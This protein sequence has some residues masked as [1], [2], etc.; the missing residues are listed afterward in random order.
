MFLGL[1]FVSTPFLHHPFVFLSIHAAGQVILNRSQ[2]ILDLHLPTLLKAL[3]DLLPLNDTNTLFILTIS[4]FVRHENNQSRFNMPSTL[5]TALAA[6]IFALCATQSS[7]HIMVS[8]FLITSYPFA[9][10]SRRL[11]HEEEELIPNS[12]RW[13]HRYPTAKA[14]ST[15]PRSHLGPTTLVNNAQ[16]YTRT[17]ERE[18]KIP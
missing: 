9:K 2:F 4:K 17:R 14:H 1:S 18:P 7:G 12:F 15:I 11:G 3:Q 13:R 16:A 6:A 10:A 5:T 8:K